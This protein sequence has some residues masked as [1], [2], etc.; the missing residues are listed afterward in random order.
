M[1]SFRFVAPIYDDDT[2]LKAITT[3]AVLPV[4]VCLVPGTVVAGLR[5]GAV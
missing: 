3:N 5:E 2:F 1:I 4:A